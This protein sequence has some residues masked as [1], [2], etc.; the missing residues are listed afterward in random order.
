[1]DL[2][3]GRAGHAV[4][5]DAEVPQD[6][7]TTPRTAATTITRNSARCSV[8]EPA[9]ASRAPRPRVRKRQLARLIVRR[10]RARPPAPCRAPCAR[11]GAARRSPPRCRRAW[12]AGAHDE[13]DVVGEFGERPHGVVGQHRAAVDD[14]EIDV[15]AGQLSRRSP[16]RSRL[17]LSARVAL[18]SGRKLEPGLGVVE[19]HR[20][21]RRAPLDQVEQAGIAAG[22]ERLRQRARARR[23][24]RPAERASRRRPRSARD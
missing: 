19:Q 13:H 22:V 10:P 11:S 5:V 16:A 6:A 7:R 12:P 20:R 23:L 14:D 1:M 21:E 18:P 17:R 15:R 3:R 9:A 2:R 24:H 8:R 4:V